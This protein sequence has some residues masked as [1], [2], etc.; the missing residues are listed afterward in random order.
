M[1]FATSEDG[2]ALTYA[3][4]VPA[5]LMPTTVSLIETWSPSMTTLVFT[6]AQPFFATE[7]YSPRKIPSRM[8][9]FSE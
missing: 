5:R 9:F 3:F 2:D 6:P 7:L 1:P 4:Q 8:A